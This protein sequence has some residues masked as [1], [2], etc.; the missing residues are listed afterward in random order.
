MSVVAQPARPR[1][2]YSLIH[3]MSCANMPPAPSVRVV[4]GATRKSARTPVHVTAT[5]SH[6]LLQVT[7]PLEFRIWY[8]THWL[9]ACHR[10]GLEAGLKPPCGFPEILPV[11]PRDLDQLIQS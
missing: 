2:S 5:A 11:T 10:T 4:T 3:P 9:T 7:G 8:R 6:V 1:E